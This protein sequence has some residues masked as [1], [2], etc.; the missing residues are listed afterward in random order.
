[1]GPDVADE[2]ERFIAAE[3]LWRSDDLRTIVERLDGQPDDLCRDLAA[4]LSSVLART[5]RGPVS[6]RLAADIEA[7]VYPRLWKLMEAVR[8]GLPEAEQRIRLEVLGGHLARL[9][10]EDR[11]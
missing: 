5:L 3:G 6:V 2:L 10:V 9:V 7:V 4:D 8:D 1:V 11:P